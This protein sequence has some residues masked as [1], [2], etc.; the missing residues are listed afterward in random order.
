LVDKGT[1]KLAAETAAH[2]RMRGSDAVY[3]AVALRFGSLL[4]TMDQEQDERL[5]GVLT[6]C[7]P[8]QVFED[9][10]KRT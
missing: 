1:A 3:T 10:E 8:A 4:V 7:S 9:L 2:H 5:K 6:V